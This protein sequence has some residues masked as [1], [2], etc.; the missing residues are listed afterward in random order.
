MRLFFYSILFYTLLLANRARREQQQEQVEPE[1][2]EFDMERE[3]QFWRL[4][5]RER[6]LKEQLKQVRTMKKGLEQPKVGDVE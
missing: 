4:Q 1:F 2:T 6:Q 5:A 3:R